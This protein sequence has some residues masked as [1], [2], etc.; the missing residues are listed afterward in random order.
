MALLPEVPSQPLMGVLMRLSSPSRVLEA[1]WLI[2]QMLG[3]S[4]S[5]SLVHGTSSWADGLMAGHDIS[6]AQSGH[7]SRPV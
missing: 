3:P 7:C 5:P 6:P 1:G 4:Q 2:T